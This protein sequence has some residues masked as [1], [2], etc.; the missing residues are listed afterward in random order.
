MKAEIKNFMGCVQATIEAS[1]I[2]LLVGLN[3][4][5][6]S[7]TL[8]PVA[9]ALTGQTVPLGLRKTD[10]G[11]LVHTGTTGGSI[12]LTGEGGVAEINWPKAE[13]RTTG[14]KPPKSSQIAAGLA[15]ILDMAEKQRVEFLRDLLKCMPEKQDLVE[16]LKAQG[17]EDKI[18][19]N[20]WNTIDRDGWEATHKRGS[21]KGRE[22]KAQWGYV[23]GEQYGSKKAESWLPDGWDSALIGNSKDGLEAQ[24]TN[25]KAEQDDSIARQAIADED[26]E[27]LMKVAEQVPDLGKKLEALKL[28]AKSSND[29]YAK[30]LES[31]KEIPSLPEQGV[32]CPYCGKSVSIRSGEKLEQIKTMSAEE[33]EAIKARAAKAGSEMA[34]IKKLVDAKNEAVR[35]TEAELAAAKKAEAQL[36]A[37]VNRNASVD[38][39]NSKREAVRKAEAQLEAFKKFTEAQRLHNNVIQNQIIVDALDENGVRRIAMERGLKAFNER[40]SEVCVACGWAD[41][42]F[43]RDLTALFNERPYVLLSASEQFRVRVTLQLV[44]ADIDGSDAVVIDGAELLDTK[45]RAG[46]LRALSKR[47]QRSFVGMMANAPDKVPNLQKMGCG[48]VYWIEKG[49]CME[50][51]R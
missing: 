24:V 49:N 4:Q 11:Q 44:I 27:K 9:S 31:F 21:D 22:F 20:L 18:I 46:L 19:E 2:A 13:L 6:K 36:E 26:R 5:G 47:K 38:E 34:E 10:A 7:S 17:I 41:V 40:L 32:P 45:G 39:V 33:V 15:S 1:P 29:A 8:R 51:E 35:K 23:T 16:V 3:H 37:S 25:A 28:E 30:V 42:S 43:N 48:H 50:V 14:E 12:V